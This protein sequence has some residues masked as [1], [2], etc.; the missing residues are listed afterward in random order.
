MKLADNIIMQP[1]KCVFCEKVDTKLRRREAETRR[2]T[3][4][5]R[6]GRNPASIEKGL[7]IIKQLD[8]EISALYCRISDLR[9]ALG[10]QYQ[11]QEPHRGQPLV[12]SRDQAKFKFAKKV[13][14]VEER[15]GL[16]V[17][18]QI[19]ESPF[20]F[21]SCPD[22]GSS[23]NAISLELALYF[24]LSIESSDDEI[25]KRTQLANGKWIA[26][27]GH[28]V[29]TCSLDAPEPN[30][31]RVIIHVFPTLARPGLFLGKQ[32]LEETQA[33]NRKLLRK[34]PHISSTPLV[35]SIGCPMQ[36]LSCSL[37]GIP[38]G[39]V[40]DTG[41]EVNLMLHECAENHFHL[42]P[43]PENAAVEYADGSIK[44]VLWVV[45][46]ELAVGF[47]PPVYGRP[48]KSKILYFL[49]K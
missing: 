27:C 1:T 22:T 40:P 18:F 28:I 30:T 47:E 26:S 3:R 7:E 29:V 44:E 20:T 11:P 17:T 33:R 37:N 4:W 38:I 48:Y 13:S 5:Q 46:A 8:S 32:F 35:R 10:S 21:M 6:E 24:G 36:L 2:V 39:I 19:S 45:R 14:M 25:Q 12:G 9:V 41:A 42:D 16:P 23:V 49:L 15:S 34:L 43:A 31:Y